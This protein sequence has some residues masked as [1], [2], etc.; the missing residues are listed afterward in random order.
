MGQDFRGFY[1]E[2]FLRVRVVK[3]R[4][5][6][7]PFLLSDGARGERRERERGGVS[8]PRGERRGTKE[9][10]VAHSEKDHKFKRSDA[11]TFPGDVYYA[12]VTCAD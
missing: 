2:S 8:R 12:V 4:V 3:Q 1:G 5:I 10:E 9:G 11:I 7:E 6:S